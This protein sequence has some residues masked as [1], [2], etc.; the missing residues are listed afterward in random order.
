MHNRTRNGFLVTIGI[1]EMAYG[2]A[3]NFERI[4]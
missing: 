1:L 4:E 3:N 2:D